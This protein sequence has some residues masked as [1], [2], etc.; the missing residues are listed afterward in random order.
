MFDMRVEVRQEGFEE[1]EE[2]LVI[3]RQVLEFVEVFLDLSGV[4]H[5]PTALGNILTAMCCSR[6]TSASFVPS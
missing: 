4:S 6:S 2:I 1:G 3:G 5:S